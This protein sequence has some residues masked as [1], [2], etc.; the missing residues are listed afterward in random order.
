M[1]KRLNRYNGGDAGPRRRR[2]LTLVELLVVI[3]LVVLLAAYYLSTVRMAHNGRGVVSCQS[4]LRQIGIAFR[5]WEGDY[6]NKYPMSV[7]TNNGGSMEYAASDN[8][9]WHFRI[10]SNEVNNPQ[11]LHCPGD[12]RPADKDTDFVNLSNSNLSY[13]IGLDSDET[14]PAMLLA[15]DRKLVTNGM[16]VVPGLAV[17]RT[18]SAA[19]WQ[20]SIH[21]G[22]GDTLFADGSVVQAK[23]A[24]LQTFLSHTGTNVNRLA[25][26]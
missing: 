6:G 7:P 4:N 22:K 10:M 12:E 14:R 16:L 23:S 3:L 26:P 9:F 13:F 15:G 21:N 25:V 2:A 11:I 17:L 24:G 8:M 18:D 1:V 20:A 5:T 19:G